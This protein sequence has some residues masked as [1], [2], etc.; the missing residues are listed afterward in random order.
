MDRLVICLVLIVILLRRGVINL[1][2]GRHVLQECPGQKAFSLH[3]KLSLH[4]R[5]FVQFPLVRLLVHNFDLYQTRG[6]IPLFRAMYLKC[7]HQ[8]IKLSGGDL[9]IADG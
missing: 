2:I 3:F 7:F 8:L 5:V 1:R 6:N 9:F 4:I